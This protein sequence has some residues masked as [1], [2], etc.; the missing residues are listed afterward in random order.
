MPPDAPRDQP[1]AQFPPEVVGALRA[2]HQ[3]PAV[4]STLDAAVLAA[5]DRSTTA[6]GVVARISPARWIAAAAAVALFA[7]TVVIYYQASRIPGDLNRDR[8]ID[9]LDALALSIAVGEGRPAPDIDR[10]GS[11]TES[12]ARALAQLA[13]RLPARGQS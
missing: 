12:D 10:D 13:V 1:T 3:P 11:A 8:R 5:F 2:A 9:I 6:T 4:P 7:G